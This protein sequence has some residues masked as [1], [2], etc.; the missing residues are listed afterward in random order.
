MF[1]LWTIVRFGAAVVAA[2][3]L[4][5]V[6]AALVCNFSS[7]EPPLLKEPASRPLEEIPEYVNRQDLQKI[8]RVSKATVIRRIRDWKKLQGS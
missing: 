7:I 8:L 5:L 3:V 4:Y 6:G 1:E 2:I